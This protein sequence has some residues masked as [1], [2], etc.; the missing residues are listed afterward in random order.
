MKTS[1]SGETEAWPQ[2]RLQL[3]LETCAVSLETGTI[4]E[5]RKTPQLSP[6]TT[7]YSLLTSF[8]FASE[9][10]SE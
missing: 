9:R 1:R 7:S 6:T 4:S 10:S 3:G 2:F 5:L 8:W